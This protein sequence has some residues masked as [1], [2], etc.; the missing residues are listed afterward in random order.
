LLSLISHNPSSIEYFQSQ[1]ENLE[2]FIQDLKI[3]VEQI[4]R[5]LIKNRVSLLNIFSH[6]NHSVYTIFC[7]LN[8][9]P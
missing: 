2:M 6:S 9:P 4:S 3:R 5:K 7:A 8:F 1:M